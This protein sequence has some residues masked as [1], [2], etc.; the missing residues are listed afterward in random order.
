MVIFRIISNLF[1]IVTRMAFNILW[2][3][4]FIFT[5]HIYL[6]LILIAIFIAWLMIHSPEN[7]VKTANRNKPTYATDAS[8][9]KVQVATPV[10]TVEDGNSAFTND[11]YRQMTDPEK[12]Y[13]SQIFFWAMSN[14]PENGTHSW[15]NVDIGGTIQGG[16][17]FANGSGERCRPFAEVLKVHAVQQNISGIACDNGGG[18][19]C[20]LKA[21]ATPACGLGG[22]SGGILDSLSG[23]FRKLF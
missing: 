20:K 10:R 6:T 17:V 13:Y 16:Q 3:P 18:T 15:S 23:S 11:L 9:K 7:E 1:G 22:S 19:W 21:N 12:K 5:R 8:G 2:L 14:L 4:V